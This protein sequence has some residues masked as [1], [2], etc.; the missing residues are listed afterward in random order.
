VKKLD[1]EWIPIEYRKE[2]SDRY[3]KSSYLR[4]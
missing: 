3:H 4:T 1:I 2:Y